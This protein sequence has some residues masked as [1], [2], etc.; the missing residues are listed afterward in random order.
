MADNVYAPPSITILTTKVWILLMEFVEEN[1]NQHEK[2]FNTII[3]SVNLYLHYWLSEIRNMESKSVIQFLSLVELILQT[4]TIHRTSINAILANIDMGVFEITRQI[5]LTRLQLSTFNNQSQSPQFSTLDL[6]I[7]YLNLVNSSSD[8]EVEFQNSKFIQKLIDESLT[9]F[10]DPHSFYYYIKAFTFISDTLKVRSLNEICIANGDKILTLLSKRYIELPNTV[11]LE[12]CFKTHSL[13]NSSQFLNKVSQTALSNDYFIQVIW[14]G[15]FSLNG[16]SLEF[17]NWIANILE[18]NLK[19]NLIIEYDLNPMDNNYNTNNNEQFAGIWI[20]SILF[21]SMEL[22]QDDIQLIA[23]LITDS[24]KDK[25]NIKDNNSQGNNSYD[26][27]NSTYANFNYNNLLIKL[28]ICRLNMFY[29][30]NEIEN[31]EFLTFF[32]I[33]IKKCKFLPMI[34]STSAFAKSIRNL[35]EFSTPD[36]K[37]DINSLIKFSFKSQNQLPNHLSFIKWIRVLN[38]DSF[39]NQQI[40]NNYQKNKKLLKRF[41]IDLYVNIKTND[42]LS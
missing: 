2:Y 18:S 3:E 38:G 41:I 23:D 35:I 12:Y 7:N 36:S 14:S 40:F 39:K 20:S 22:K 16:E 4:F 24:I 28:L 19:S 42:I 34:N 1:W 29:A 37:F 6:T 9:L 8:V 32:Q 13:I 27:I 15:G 26:E 10:D 5:I 17:F 30:F 11:L 33:L 31:D 25:F 21:E